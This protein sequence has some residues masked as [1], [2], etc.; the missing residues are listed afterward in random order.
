MPFGLNRIV[1]HGAL[2]WWWARRYGYPT[3]A[4]GVEVPLYGWVEAP[5][6]VQAAAAMPLQ[7]QAAQSVALPANVTSFNR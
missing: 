7:D 2:G 5:V 6:E 1:T 4:H 3:D